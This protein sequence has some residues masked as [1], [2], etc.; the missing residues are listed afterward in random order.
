MQAATIERLKKIGWH[1]NRKIDV[2]PIKNRYEEI[3]LEFPDNVSEFLERFGMLKIDIP[4]MNNND[5][6]LTPIDAIG[7]NV[8]HDYF[9]E[10]LKDYGIEEDVFPIGET[11][12][13]NLLLLMTKENVFYEFTDGCVIKNGESIDEM[14]DILIGKCK[15][16]IHIC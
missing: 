9:E 6:N 10:C 2:S 3:G 1:E 12:R 8:E 13:G 4:E 7:I 11:C 14:L 5:V 16:G 15:K